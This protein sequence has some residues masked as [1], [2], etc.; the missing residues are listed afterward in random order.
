[1]SASP[2]GTLLPV[3]VPLPRMRVRQ[4]GV[5]QPLAAQAHS[6]SLFLKPDGTLWSWGGNTYG[7]LGDGTTTNRV[8][9]V[10]VSTLADVRWVSG[11]H[12]NTSTF[13]LAVTGSGTLYSW[14]DNSAGQLGD[15]TT[16]SHHTPAAVSN[17]TN[18]I[19]AKAGEYYSTA[20]KSDGTVWSWGSNGF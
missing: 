4:P 3:L 16:T 12:G 18:V 9:P 6:S 10:N 13:A 15:G 8:Q 14:G 20:L 11:G 17:L 2:S 19:Q 5:T 1:G 7:Q